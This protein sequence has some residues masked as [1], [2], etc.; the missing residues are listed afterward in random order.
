M[1]CPMCIANAALA[2]AGATT[3]GGAAAMALRILRRKRGLKRKAEEG[4]PGSL[5]RRARDR[6]DRAVRSEEHH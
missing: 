6:Q 2:V 4:F 5:P 3:S 1:L